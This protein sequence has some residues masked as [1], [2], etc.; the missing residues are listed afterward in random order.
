VCDWPGCLFAI[1]EDSEPVQVIRAS[2]ERQGWLVHVSGWAVHP[3]QDGRRRF[4]FCPLHAREHARERLV[5]DPP[6][7]PD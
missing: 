6:L 4:D 2:A 7:E 3:Q 5:E 1:T